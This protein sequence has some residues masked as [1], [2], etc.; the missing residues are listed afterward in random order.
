MGSAL[1][2]GEKKKK[3]KKKEGEGKPG[4]NTGRKSG[5]TRLCAKEVGNF[6]I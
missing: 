3:E 6:V 5:L 4:R 2:T 1:E